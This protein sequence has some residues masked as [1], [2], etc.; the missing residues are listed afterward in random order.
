MAQGR[1]EALIENLAVAS[2]VGFL[3]IIVAAASLVSDS[4]ES[5]AEG[6]ALAEAF[7]A[8]GT[9]LAS[10]VDDP[11][12]ECLYSLKGVDAASFGT[13]IALRSQGSSTLVGALFSPQGELR[14][15][16]VLG[17]AESRRSISKEAL[18]GLLPDADEALERA[19]RAVRSA[20]AAAAKE[21]GS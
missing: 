11:C 10:R 8:S 16:R 13:V 5:A 9:E 3:V 6:S 1:R 19:A 4:R 17:D 21:A 18:S 2:A 7:S 15:L 20:A 12:F 14:G